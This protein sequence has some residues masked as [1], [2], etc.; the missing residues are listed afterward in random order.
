MCRAQQNRHHGWA[1]CPLA[2]HTALARHLHSPSLSHA[3]KPGTLLVIR[4]LN[5]V[6]RGERER[7]KEGPILTKTPSTQNAPEP[8]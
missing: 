7:D 5:V 3:V 1:A 8:P 6:Q 2:A 4:Q